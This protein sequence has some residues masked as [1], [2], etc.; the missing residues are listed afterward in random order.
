MEQDKVNQVLRV[1]VL[2]SVVREDL[3]GKETFEQWLS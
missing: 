1:A 3:I 2:N